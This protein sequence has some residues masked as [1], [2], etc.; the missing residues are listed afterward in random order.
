MTERHVGST[1]VV[2]VIRSIAVP[3]PAKS[4]TVARS[5]RAFDEFLI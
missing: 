4:V 1:M 5:L 2:L 3:K